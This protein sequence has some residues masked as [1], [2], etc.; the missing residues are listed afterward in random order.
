MLT[1]FY[2]YVD[3]MFFHCHVYISLFHRY[4]HIMLFH[5]QVHIILFHIL[6]IIMFF[7][8]HVYNIMSC[9]HFTFFSIIFICCCFTPFLGGKW[10]QHSHSMLLWVSS[11]L[12]QGKERI[13][14]VKYMVQREEK[15]KVTF[16]MGEDETKDD[17]V[18]MK[19][20]HHLFMQCNQIS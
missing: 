7:H 11:I 12:D 15:N 6:V 5:L 17:F 4:I 10:G 1:C 2:C 20:E 14:C 16:R 3:A 9:Y 8:S 19:K 18:L 13:M